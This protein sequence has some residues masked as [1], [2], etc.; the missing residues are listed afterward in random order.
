MCYGET[1]VTLR[2]QPPIHLQ[3]SNS[4]LSAT[5]LFRDNNLVPGDSLVYA[6]GAGSSPSGVDVVPLVS[7]EDATATTANGLS[8]Q[9]CRAC[10][11]R[12]HCGFITSHTGDVYVYAC[13]RT[14]RGTTPQCAP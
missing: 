10:H 11:G 8:L 3:R 14:E 9:V 4:S 1:L 5:W 6:W 13:D 2:S 12:A 7:V